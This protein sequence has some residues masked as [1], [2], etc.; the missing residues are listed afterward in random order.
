MNEPGRLEAVDRADFEH[1]L[2]EALGAPDI[3]EA[4]QQPCA[5][6]TAEQLHARALAAA[7]TIA[8]EASTE[9]AALLRLRTTPAPARGGRPQQPAHAT[10]G[11]GLLAALAVLTPLLS[12]AAAAIFLLLGYG[13]Q[14]AGAQ[15]P[16]AI[17]LIRTGWITGAIAVLAAAA[18]GTA[19]VIT[20]AR[21]RATSRHPQP[22]AAA[23]TQAHAAWRRALLERGLLPFLR[24]QLHQPPAAAPQPRPLRLPHSALA[25][26]TAARTSPAPPSL[27]GLTPPPW[28]GTQ[29]ETVPP[30]EWPYPPGPGAPLP[31]ISTVL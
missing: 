8:A 7:D 27:P 14:L 17:A 3:R 22:D 23:L 28:V 9:Y 5:Q 6:V 29:A 12:A 11:D 31:T 16:L 13:I 24:H 26:A 19:L 2:H 15:Q 1:T 25:P 30:R 21:H 18:A 10:V 4:L 20:A